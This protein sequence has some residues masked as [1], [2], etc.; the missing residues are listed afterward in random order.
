MLAASSVMVPAREFQCGTERWRGARLHVQQAAAASV[1]AAVVKSAVNEERNGSFVTRV[2]RLVRLAWT[3]L[4]A[5][6]S[7]GLW[8]RLVS[9]LPRS[10]SRS[11]NPGLLSGCAASAAAVIPA[12]PGAATVKGSASVCGLRRGRG[13]VCRGDRH[14][15]FGVEGSRGVGRECDRLGHRRD[16]ALDRSS[17][18][19]RP[20]NHSLLRKP[21]ASTP[22]TVAGSFTIRSASVIV[23]L[24]ATPGAVLNVAALP[25]SVTA[26][27]AGTVNVSV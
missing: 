9:A 21:T 11:L 6:G 15:Q 12:T 8:Y 5:T 19:C 13:S 17:A 18:E 1:V 25:V 10:P 14:A 23:S 7:D 4:A 2:T 16:P 26:S 24:A 20:Q 27:I 22:L 3:W